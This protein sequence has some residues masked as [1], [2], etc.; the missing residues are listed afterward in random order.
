MAINDRE[1][2]A[3][4]AEAST[5]NEPNGC[6]AWTRGIFNAPSVGDFDG[7]GRADAEDGWKS[8]PVKYRHPGDRN[9][10]RGVPVSYLG[11][12]HDDGHRAISLGNGMI[13]ST[14][15]GG[16]GRIA[17]VRLDWPERV[18]GL[19]YAGWSETIDGQL[20]PLPA[21]PAKAA[22]L[23]PTRLSRARALLRAALAAAKRKGN[24]RRAR[25][26]QDALDNAPER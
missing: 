25:R 11:G 16:R 7:D 22:P 24:A 3:R 12:S 26:I 5:T 21:P 2:A 14:D 13:R 18:W 6:Q 23:P 20:I 4:R 15:A 10:P 19:K 9:P 17:T 1:Q 8:E